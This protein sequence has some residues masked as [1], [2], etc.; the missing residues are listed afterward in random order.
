MQAVKDLGHRQRAHPRRRQFDRQ[1]YPIQS[2]ADLRDGSR[3]VVRDGEV[4]LGQPGPVGEQFDRL[5]DHRQRRHP[6]RRLTRNTDRLTTCREHGQ[7]RRRTQQ[8]DDQLCARVQQVLAVVQHHQHSAIAHKAHHRVDRRAP[9][10]IRQPQRT[11]HRQR[12]HRRIG[13][14]RQVHIPDAIGVFGRQLVRDFYRQPRL[15][16]PTGSGQGDQAVAGQQH[17]HL[18]NLGATADKAGELGRKI[19]RSNTSRRAQR[20]EVVAQI[21]MTQLHHPLRAGNTPQLVTAQIGQPHIGGQCVRDHVLGRPRQH[22][23][24]TMSQIAQP[25]RPV[26]RRTDVIA[27]IAQLHLTGMHADPQADR[28]QRRA[29]QLQRTRHRVSGPRERHHETVALA[30]LHRPHPAIGGE[31]IRQRLIQPRERRRH[32]LGLGLPQPG[33]ILDVRQKQRHRARRQKPA[34]AKIAPVHQRR[35][36]AWI[37]LAHASQHAA[38]QRLKHQRKRV[39]PAT[40]QADFS[41]SREI[42][43]GELLPEPAAPARRGRVWR[44][45]G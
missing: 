34:H 1:R 42:R 44:R 8:S 30:L 21:G 20:R 17:A 11:R 10:L 29:L 16:H 27:L 33:G 24:P 32:L 35:I 3:V 28:R 45:R 41:M 15:A 7:P 40:S 43:R 31:Q 37:N 13:D 36:H 9:G 14:R 2:P 6:P 38:G 12:R 22:R 5:I 4:T 25:R 18:G 39:V 26:D 23:L 19:T